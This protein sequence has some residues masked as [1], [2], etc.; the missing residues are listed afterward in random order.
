MNIIETKRTFLRKF[1]MDDLDDLSA[2]FSNPRVMK[3]LGLHCQP[4]SREETREILESIIRLW[5]NRGYGRMAVIS[6]ENNK[7]IGIAGLR[8]FEGDA[9]LFYLL[10][11]PYW[12]KGLATEIA[13]AVLQ[14]GFEVHNFPRI[15]AATRPANAATLRVLDKL[16]MNFEKVDVIVG[17]RA[18]RYVISQ[19]D[20]QLK[21]LMMSP[22]LAQSRHINNKLIMTREGFKPSKQKEKPGCLNDIQVYSVSKQNPVPVRHTQKN[23]SVPTFPC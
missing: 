13:K 8:Y 1:T 19:K 11:E 6:K 15:I 16:G 18:F 5:Q 10:D 17:V 21:R 22:Y 20:F 23:S 3:Y 9:E 2:I 7:L 12:G 4:I 14:Y